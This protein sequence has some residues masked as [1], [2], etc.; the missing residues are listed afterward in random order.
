MPKKVFTSGIPYPPLTTIDQGG[1]LKPAQLAVVLGGTREGWSVCVRSESGKPKR[2]GYF[3]HISRDENAK[4]NFVLKDFDKISIARSNGDFISFDL[5][6]LCE[7]INHCTGSHFSK[8]MLI[9]S[10][11]EINFRS[12][13]DED[14]DDD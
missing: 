6:S 2:G 1:P 8:R 9:L 11:S 3:F 7:F 4:G 5:E 13:P 14:K 10:Q 12:D